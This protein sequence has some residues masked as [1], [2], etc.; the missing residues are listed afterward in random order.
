[1]ATEEVEI[2][3]IEGVLSSLS[4]KQ[5][6]I[7]ATPDAD[8]GFRM[9]GGKDNDGSGNVTKFLAK[10]QDAYIDELRLEGPTTIGEIGM[11]KHD[12]NGDITGG[13][14]TVD[15]FNTNILSDGPIGG[16]DVLGSGT[17][18]TLAMWTDTDTIGDSSITKSSNLYSVN[19]ESTSHSVTN[20]IVLSQLEVNGTSFFDSTASFYT[21]AF[22]PD[23]A[24]ILLG[25]DTDDVLRHGTGQNPHSLMLGLGDDSNAVIVSR[26]A[27]MGTDYGLGPFTNPTVVLKGTGT[28]AADRT[29]L[30]HGLVNVASGD[31]QVNAN[32][33]IYDYDPDSH[34]FDDTFGVATGC[35]VFGEEHT[36][37]GQYSANTAIFGSENEVNGSGSLIS[38]HNNDCTNVTY[39]MIGGTLN[40]VDTRYSIV[41]GQ[42]NTVTDDYG[43]VFGQSNA[44]HG[45]HSLVA[46]NDITSY[47]DY[48]V[49]AGTSHAL[50]SGC[51]YLNISG[52]SIT[53]TGG[54][55]SIAAGTGHTVTDSYGLTY[56][57][58]NENDHEHA[59]VHGSFAKSLWSG[60][61]HAGTRL[62]GSTTGISQSFSQTT[63]SRH[64]TST[65]PV[66]L[67]HTGSGTT[68]PILIPEARLVSFLVNITCAY[69]AADLGY[70]NALYRIL[71]DRTAAEGMG[72]V[73]SS[74]DN[75]A[76]GTGTFAIALQANG[77]DNT[78]EIEITPSSASAANIQANIALGNVIMSNNGIS[79]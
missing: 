37:H 64:T 75:V 16:G 73:S 3:H 21:N 23:N 47:S 36:V 33:F 1:M 24:E 2:L 5:I 70:R 20:G 62:D 54:D 72:V 8:L 34:T 67:T 79:D 40:N 38:G 27:D 60:N 44:N 35:A 78:F 10:G 46:G 43:G 61:F 50:S 45:H 17:A 7:E 52:S 26:E 9:W 42:S 69:E 22:F 56:G 51:D 25:D 59:T 18:N 15:Y 12:T 66:I 76:A 55:Y 53:V 63:L 39:S 58:T 77:T 13:Q 14:I 4:K 32:N 71:V 48:S 41:G 74:I 57:A 30:S 65:S 19:S 31:Y 28:T 29:E 11:L 6:G 68:S 49:I